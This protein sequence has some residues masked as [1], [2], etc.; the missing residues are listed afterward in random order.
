MRQIFLLQKFISDSEKSAVG[1]F[2]MML[3]VVNLM[4][5]YK[6]SISQFYFILTCMILEMTPWNSK[7]ETGNERGKQL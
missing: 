3:L 6:N 5:D 4:Q 2:D 1:L 7:T